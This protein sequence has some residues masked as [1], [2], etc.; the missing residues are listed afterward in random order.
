MYPT[1][2]EMNPRMCQTRWHN[3]CD[4]KLNESDSKYLEIRNLPQEMV[5]ENRQ[6]LGGAHAADVLYVSKYYIN[7][8]SAELT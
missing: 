7:S 3:L 6:Y 4:S 1:L 2:G 5:N 8:V